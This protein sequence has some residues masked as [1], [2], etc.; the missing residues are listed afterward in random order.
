MQKFN[1]LPTYGKQEIELKRRIFS[2]A[3]NGVAKIP[4]PHAASLSRRYP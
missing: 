1:E 2:R 3:H 4:S